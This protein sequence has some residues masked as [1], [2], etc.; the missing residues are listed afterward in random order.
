VKPLALFAAVAV[1]GAAAPVVASAREPA[2]PAPN[3]LLVVTDD[4]RADTLDVMPR[5]RRWLGEGGTTFG[6]AY[7]TTPLCCPSRSS[8]LSGR[9]AHNHG[10]RTNGDG[11]R[12]DQDTTL[13]ARLRRKGYQTAISGK[14]LLG[15]DLAT[16]PPHFDRWAITNGTQYRGD[17]FS[18]DGARRKVSDYSTTFIGDRALEY[19]DHFEGDDTRPWFLYVAPQAA[20]R[21]YRA[22]ARYADAEVPPWRPGPGVTE[23][24]RSDKPEWVRH[25]G[26]RG[27]RDLRADQL[28]TLLSADDMMAAVQRRLVAL[29]EERDTLVIFTSDNGYQWGEHGL[30]SKSLPYAESV[31]VPLLLRWPGRVPEG[32]TTRRLVST[33]DIAAT[34]LAGA[35][36]RVRDGEAPLDGRSQLSH[37]SRSRLLVEYQKDPFFPYPTWAS[38]RGPG[39]VYTEWYG[40]DD[41]TVAFREYYDLRRDPAENDNLLGDGVAENDPPVADLSA[42]LARARRCAG[43]RCP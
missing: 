23:E 31:R 22:E 32:G 39:V 9:Y 1:A 40:D 43:W 30:R 36:V 14:F 24:D 33:A 3:V 35:G 25:W 16:P 7:V 34:V 4:Q 20:H 17:W 29:D 2:Q 10:V 27:G 41:E 15:W 18:I 5:T 38:L 19:L 13:A 28:R 8:I 42:E 37:R 11:N 6:Q 12:L 21:P 26:F